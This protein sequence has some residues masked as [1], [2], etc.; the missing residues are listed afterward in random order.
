[1]KDFTRSVSV[2]IV[3]I[4]FSRQEIE[5]F[6]CV[7]HRGLDQSVDIGSL[8]VV[9]FKGMRSNYA[10]ACCVWVKIS[11]FFF[12]SFSVF[13]VCLLL[14]VSLFAEAWCDTFESLAR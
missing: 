9:R 4:L 8:P 14:A 3:S 7:V 5:A 6:Q 1:L 10:E 2:T 12:F 11:L 13:L